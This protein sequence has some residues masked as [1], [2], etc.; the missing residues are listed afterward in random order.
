MA[1]RA[2][3]FIFDTANTFT[4]STATPLILALQFVY[5]LYNVSLCFDL[6]YITSC[7]FCIPNSFASFG[8]CPLLQSIYTRF[9]V[10]VSCYHIAIPLF[11][12]RNVSQ[13]QIRL[14]KENMLALV[15]RL[16]N[17]KEHKMSSN[18][19]SLAKKWNVDPSTGSDLGRDCSQFRLATE[20]DIQEFLKNRPY[21]YGRWMLIVQ[22]WEPNI[23][24]SFQSQILFWITIRGIPLHYW[25]EKRVRNIGLEPGELENY[26]V[27]MS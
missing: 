10:Y 5:T 8:L 21:Q 23:S 14:I 24:Q 18:L 15:G 16:T 6:Y 12:W 27:W 2:S 26:V 1:E 25:H 13:Q 17:P 4:Q 22:R 11:L 20:E 7:Y 3:R 19:P 9:L